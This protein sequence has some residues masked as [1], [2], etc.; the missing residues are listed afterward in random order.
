MT[1]VLSEKNNHSHRDHL[2]S[3]YSAVCN[4]FYINIQIKGCWQQNFQQKFCIPLGFYLNHI[5]QNKSN[6]DFNV[7]AN[8]RY[9]YYK[10]RDLVKKCKGNCIN[11][12]NCYDVFRDV[13]KRRTR[14]INVP[15]ICKEV[16]KDMCIIEEALSDVFYYLDE[17][18]RTLNELKRNRNSCEHYKDKCEEHIGRLRNCDFSGNLSLMKVIEKFEKEYYRECPMPVVPVTIQYPN[19]DILINGKKKATSP[20]VMIDTLTGTVEEA[21]TNALNSTLTGKGTGVIV[22]P[23]IMLTIVFVL[24]KYTRYGSLLQLG[25]KAL[26]CMLKKKKV[27]DLMT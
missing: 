26:K 8:C 16:V 24:Y 13:W 5:E 9:F 20:G 14:L 15:D 18:Y 21:T 10:L 17:L 27:K 11:N 3:G 2:Y 4:N 1:D 12:K 23:F 6:K 19:P 25:V 7:Q 22:L